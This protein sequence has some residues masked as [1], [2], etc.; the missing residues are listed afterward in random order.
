M[1]FS[2]TVFVYVG[3]LVFDVILAT[4]VIGLFADLKIIW[5]PVIIAVVGH[6]LLH[7]MQR[8]P[9][10]LLVVVFAILTVSAVAHFGLPAAPPAEVGPALGWNPAAFFTLFSVAAG[11][12]IS[13]A[14]YVSDYTRY[15]PATASATQTDCLGVR[16]RRCVGC[17]AEISGLAVGSP[18]CER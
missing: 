15:L 2:A 8:W 18:H 17:V 10:Y 6:D 14:V 9:T 1:P 5:Y 13:Y 16:R 4:Q 3:F 11:Y 12:N 7:L